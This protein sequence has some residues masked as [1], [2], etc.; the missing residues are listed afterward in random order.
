MAAT[1]PLHPAAQAY[2]DRDRPI[3]RADVAD[4]VQ[5]VLGGIAPLVGGCVALYGFYR[6]RQLMQFLHYYREL[7]SL[8]LAAKG[9]VAADH[10]PAA[11]PDRVRHLEAE[12][13]ELQR[14]AVDAFCRSYFY[15]E[16]VLYNFLAL[17]TE[18]RD[19]LRRSEVD[20]APIGDAT[21]PAVSVDHAG[22]ERSDG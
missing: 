16:G 4:M 6:W 14:K 2:R 7:Q 8:D 19:F 10:L 18:T 12:L 5:R 21:R 9:L 22:V 20:L 3:V 1:Y 15:G 13:V 17:L 11:G